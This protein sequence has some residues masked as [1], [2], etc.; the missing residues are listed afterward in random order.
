MDNRRAR[1]SLGGLGGTHLR[2][3]APGTALMVLC[4]VVP[5]APLVVQHHR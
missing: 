2:K 1:K 4:M 3:R 5:S